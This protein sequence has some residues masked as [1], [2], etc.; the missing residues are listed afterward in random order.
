MKDWHSA[1]NWLANRNGG[2]EIE[3]DKKDGDDF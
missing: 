2:D 3:A 1:G